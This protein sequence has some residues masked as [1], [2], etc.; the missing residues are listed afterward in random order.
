MACATSSSEEQR[1]ATPLHADLCLAVPEYN[2]LDTYNTRVPLSIAAAL[3]QLSANRSFVEIGTR[4]GD[5]FLCVSHLAS[6]TMVIEAKQE[7]CSHLFR[8]AEHRARVSRRSVQVK[9]PEFFPHGG[10]E[11]ADAD[12]IFSWMGPTI[13]M[14]ILQQLL[15]GVRAGRIRS[16]AMFYTM[17]N[18]LPSNYISTGAVP[19][20][21]WMDVDLAR[22]ASRVY[23][24]PFEEDAV[25]MSNRVEKRHVKGTMTLL[26]FHLDDSELLRRV[27]S[28]VGLT[29]ETCHARYWT[30]E[31]CPTPALLRAPLDRMTR[32][33]ARCHRSVQRWPAG[34]AARRSELDS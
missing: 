7:Y 30:H 1:T 2:V 27:E 3:A 28:G 4:K 26:E 22:Y 13:E 21:L 20:N 15:K 25:I 18:A 16:T 34:C 8:R 5:I 33:A 11:H 14:T 23:A 32:F 6:R 17:V 12:V 24:V 19:K 31:A 9:C 29:H 10:V